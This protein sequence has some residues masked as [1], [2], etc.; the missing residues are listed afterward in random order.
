M[1]SGP[2]NDAQ[3]KVVAA[4]LLP[5]V[6]PLTCPTIFMR[7]CLSASPSFYCTAKTC[8]A[9]TQKKNSCQTKTMPQRTKQG[10]VQKWWAHVKLCHCS[11]LPN[12]LSHAEHLA[13]ESQQH[14]YSETQ[15]PRPTP[16]LSCVDVSCCKPFMKLSL[17][18]LLAASAA[19]DHALEPGPGFTHMD[20]Q[21]GEPDLEC[22]PTANLQAL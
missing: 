21:T 9:K 5:F 20:C 1:L 2:S 18:R 4:A 16:A 6:S 8:T 12:S 15:P 10:V 19:I 22:R 13:C 7:T 11:S 3:T 17:M 14:M